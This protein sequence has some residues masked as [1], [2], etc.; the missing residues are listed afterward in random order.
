MY[1]ENKESSS[2]EKNRNGRK[3]TPKSYEKS[4]LFRIKTEVRSGEMCVC[5]REKK[6]CERERERK[7]VNV[8]RQSAEREK[9]R[10]RK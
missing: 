3:K 1:K 10:E 8:R 7:R 4:F 9:E 5:E 6:D 2:Y